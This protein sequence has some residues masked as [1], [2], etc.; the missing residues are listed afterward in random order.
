MRSQTRVIAGVW[1]ALFWAGMAAAQTPADHGRGEG[2]SRAAGMPLRDGALAPGMLTVRV[3]RGAFSNN[4]SDQPVQVEPRDG[5]PMSART[6]TD[7]RAQFAHLPIGRTVRVSAVVDG[8]RLISDEFP[9]PS[10]SG[11]RVLLIAGGGDATAGGVFGQ[12]PVPGPATGA[13]AVVQD[14]PVPA[15]APASSTDSTVTVIRVL[16][17]GATLMAL[18]VVVGRMRHGPRASRRPGASVDE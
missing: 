18:A 1:L 8:E 15:A 3:V 16:F 12:V 7:G 11:I 6:G 9:M 2:A 14:T 17:A 13:D 4:L 5:A 10:E